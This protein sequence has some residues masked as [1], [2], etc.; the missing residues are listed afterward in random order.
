MRREKCIWKRI[1]AIL[2]AVATV[3]TTVYQPDR[4]AWAEET[5]VQ[6][7]TTASNAI[8]TEAT[9]SFG[10]LLNR[11]IEEKLDEQGKNGGYNVFSLAVDGT[12]AKVEL[13]ALE[14]CTLVVGVY[15][16]AGTTMLG[17][18]TA[19]VA[20]ASEEAEVTIE[21]DA[22]PAYFDVKAYL[23]DS[24]TLAP[25]CSVFDCPNYT[26]EM[27][28]FLQKS[29]DDFSD[30]QVLQLDD[31]GDNNFAVFQDEVQYIEE[32]EGVNQVT[33]EDT[34]NNTYV[35]E[36]ASTEIQALQPGDTTALEYHQ[37]QI[38]IIK[39]AS[40]TLDGTT[41]TIIGEETDLEDVFEYMKIDTESY[42]GDA[43]VD[44]SDLEEG[45]TYL[46]MTEA[47]E[48]EDQTAVYAAEGAT[49]DTVSGEASETLELSYSLN[50]KISNENASVSINGSLKLSITTKLKF[51]ITLSRQYFEFTNDYTMKVSVGVSG[52]LS[53]KIELGCMEFSPVTGVFV[54]LK[55]AFKVEFSGSLT[56]AA[57]VTG[58]VGGSITFG[59]DSADLNKT[60]E[61]ETSLKIEGKA[62]LGLVLKPEIVLLTDKLLEAGVECSIGA[63]INLKKDLL[64]SDSGSIHGCNHCLSGEVNGI[65][66]AEFSLKFLNLE[67]LKIQKKF[68]TRIKIADCHYSF[69]YDE[70][71]FQAC[72]HKGYEA[73]I[74]LL[75]K[76]N[77]PLS[78]ATIQGNFLTVENDVVKGISSV[79]TDEQG[80]VNIYVPYGKQKVR[81]QCDANMVETILNKLNMKESLT[82][83]VE[84]RGTIDSSTFPDEN[85]RN[86]VSVFD[87]NGD[88]ILSETEIKDVTEIDVSNKS[89]TSLKGVEVF[90]KLETLYCYGNKLSS[91]NVSRN[92]R[93]DELHC[94]NNQLSSLDLSGATALEKLHCENNQLSSLDVSANT[95]LFT[96]Y[97][98]NNQLS[99]L[100]VSV[101]T[102]LH[103]LYCDSTVQLIGWSRTS[104]SDAVLP[105]SAESE[106]NA[107]PEEAGFE[108]DRREQSEYEAFLPDIE[109][110]DE[111]AAEEAPDE[112]VITSPATYRDLLP[113]A[114]Y[115]FYVMRDTEEGISSENLLYETA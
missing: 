113:N 115:N 71:Q 30:K 75:D 15:D 109:A 32:A 65:A 10:M 106:V 39:V 85:F 18:G 1:V 74:T 56:L 17:S 108:A 100:D 66:S 9:N 47:V 51:Y 24:E 94:D 59:S 22:M 86:Y 88:G 80:K 46:G 53:D 37:G 111:E 38:L 28:E 87:K 21:I 31:S 42:T 82:Q 105:E 79:T 110:S 92:T 25:L 49:A 55:P 27:Q 64:E 23:I 6:P 35:I 81:I 62:Y 34:E 2:L 103:W 99:S 20:A 83:K 93:L 45:V 97:C 33:T 48:E 52:K 13:E 72:P 114:I 69:D 40:V 68:E 7:E 26:Q 73:D 76:Q 102:K 96:L 60:P 67:R 63:E 101:N 50:K 4:T 70:F 5:T 84:K 98:Q 112:D 61:L 95:E 54:R 89:I 3:I 78:N 107:L 12:T 58:R 29:V 36:N 90:T 57:K 104:T 11:E 16:E 8:Q 91:L 43:T 44:T 41:A 77:N 19:D 14:D